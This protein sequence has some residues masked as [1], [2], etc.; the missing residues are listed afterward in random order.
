MTSP[1]E[2]LAK[3][4]ARQIYAMP[5]SYQYEYASR[6]YRDKDGV[7]THTPIRKGKDREVDPGPLPEGG[8]PLGFV[9]NHPWVSAFTNA[10]LHPPSEIMANLPRLLETAHY[11]S[12]EDFQWAGET[13]NYVV[14]PYGNVRLFEPSWYPRLWP[15]HAASS[16]GKR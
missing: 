1:E 16:K 10:M 15:E 3:D 5:D 14:D 2:W 11:P 13:N 7:I 12:P 9:H 6:I 4:L 8:V